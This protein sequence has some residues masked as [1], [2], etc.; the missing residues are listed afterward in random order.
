MTQTSS[1]TIYSNNTAFGVDCRW[2]SS[3]VLRLDMPRVLE[4]WT[5]VNIETFEAK[6]RFSDALFPGGAYEKPVARSVCISESMN[7]LVEVSDQGRNVVILIQ[8]D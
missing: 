2:L 4:F 7:D 6:G 5:E 3:K 1:P 8:I